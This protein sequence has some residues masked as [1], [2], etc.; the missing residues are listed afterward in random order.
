MTHRIDWDKGR[1]RDL[2]RKWQSLPLGDTGVD[3]CGPPSLR[4]DREIE[5]D[6]QDVRT[7]ANRPT[8]T[9]VLK[10]TWRDNRRYTAAY[11]FIGI[12]FEEAS[13]AFP[14]R[15]WTQQEIENV[16]TEKRYRCERF[17]KEHV[18]AKRWDVN[19]FPHNASWRAEL[20]PASSHREMH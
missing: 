5:I 9:C 3:P 8:E 14:S 19:V 6:F 20:N 18:L 15:K 2:V 12:P 10:L 17:A 1:M 4:D 13:T 16:L 7:E 11:H